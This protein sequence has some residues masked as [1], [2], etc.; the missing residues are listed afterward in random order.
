MS[1]CR[2]CAQNSAWH[3]VSALKMLMI[4]VDMSVLQKRKYEREQVRNASER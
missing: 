4:I 2:S 3:R 1:Y